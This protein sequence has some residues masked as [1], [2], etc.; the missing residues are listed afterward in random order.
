MCFAVRA[1]SSTCWEMF[2]SELLEAG[3]RVPLLGSFEFLEQSDFEVCWGVE[4]GVQG[5]PG[6]FPRCCDELG[7]GIS[8]IIGPGWAVVDLE[9][10]ADTGAGSSIGLN[11]I[12]H[13]HLCGVGEFQGGPACFEDR[14]A[15]LAVTFKGGALREAEHVAVEGEGGVEVFSLDDEAK[16]LH[17]GLLFRCGMCHADEDKT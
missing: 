15:G 16:L 8:E 2:C 3:V 6:G 13:L 17:R 11:S 10:E 12:D 14:D 1:S 5:P 7:P 4:A 9:S